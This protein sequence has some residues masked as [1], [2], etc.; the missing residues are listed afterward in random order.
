ML[1]EVVGAT[2]TETSKLVEAG[3]TILENVK[4]TKL[5]INID[6]KIDVNKILEGAGK[7]IEEKS[8][9]DVIDIDEKIEVKTLA[10]VINDYISNLK[11][12]SEFSDTISEIPIDI[13]SLEKI[14]H[15]INKL[16]REKFDDIKSDLRDQWEKE[17]GIEWP[18][19]KEDVYDAN[20]NIVRHKGDRYDVH[21][22]QPLEYGGQN[23]VDNITPLAYD[24]HKE[25]HSKYSPCNKIG[26]FL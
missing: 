5:D 23:T 3:K 6:D 8:D 26:D 10:D 16:M 12:L 2:V 15:E 20:G 11:E 9:I 21:H 18:R 22:I 17:H 7:E 1:K 4:E 19:Y 14:P 25:I 24:K 13:N